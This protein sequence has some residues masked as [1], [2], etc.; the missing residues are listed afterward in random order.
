[1]QRKYV[2]RE[3]TSEGPRRR[4]G[5]TARRRSVT[6]NLAE[7]PLGWLHAHG[8]L[9]DR[10]FD[11]GERLRTDYETAQI[12]PGVT[13]RWQALAERAPARRAPA[14]RRR[15]RGGGQGSR[16]HPVA[17]RLRLRDAAGG[18]TG[19]GLADPQRQAGAQAG[20]RPGGRLLPDRVSPWRPGPLGQ[21]TVREGAL[22][23]Y[24]STSSASASQRSSA[25]SFSAR[26]LSR[27]AVKRANTSGSRP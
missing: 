26:S 17:R 4:S 22:R 18:G 23:T 24:P 20:A 5:V 3:L 16:G 7:S 11:A 14:L 15:D 1:M 19:A 27:S 10:L 21:V 13:M 25:A 9:E 8:H 12:S 2:E 6:V